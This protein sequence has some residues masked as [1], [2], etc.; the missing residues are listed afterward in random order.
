MSKQKEDK[1]KK[2]QAVSQK[3]TEMLESVQA[4]LL[5][6]GNHISQ[7]SHDTVLIEDESYRLVEDYKEGFN[8]EDFKQRY[9]DYYEKFDYLVGDWGH[10]Q[11]RLKGFYQ[12]NTPRT[13]ASQ[14]ISFLDEYLK[15]FCNFGCRYFVLAKE[16]ALDDFDQAKGQRAQKLARVQKN[17]SSGKKNNNEGLKQ[18][19]INTRHTRDNSND[20][21]VKKIRKDNF[22]VKHDQDKKRDQLGKASP[23]QAQQA[24]EKVK[25]KQKNAFTIK[26]KTN[27]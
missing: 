22:K 7:V 19:Q 15:E 9:V 24:E 2:D 1:N 14:R 5:E 26:R 17:S 18:R 23:K 12:L 25:V 13:K 21:K 11:L 8:L 27:M 10:E 3:I 6:N 4:S 20:P 16:S